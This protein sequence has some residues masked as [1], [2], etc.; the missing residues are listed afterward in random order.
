MSN[1]KH[2]PKK[3]QGRPP[4][5]KRRSGGKPAGGGAKRSSGARRDTAGRDDDKRTTKAKPRRR[6]L[7]GAAAEL[8]NWLID[9]VARTTPK[10]KVADALEAFGEAS[11][12]YTSG[13]YKTALRRAQTAK[14]LAPRSPSV[15]EVLGLAAYR[16]GDYRLALTELR[17]SRRMTGDTTHMPVEMD[18]LRALGRRD[19]VATVYDQLRQ[20][21][22]RP[23]TL[24]EAK[25]VYASHLL[26]EGNPAAAWKLTK[27]GRLG[28]DAY[29]ADHRVWYVAARAAAA[30][31][32]RETAAKIRDAILTADPSFPGI[33][34]LDSEIAKSVTTKE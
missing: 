12:A 14:E 8:P 21:G 27:P 34:E 29:E 28:A 9:E 33:D 19:D 20:L 15:R 25:V 7:R 11:A 24:K 26:D 13:R 1:G 4:P 23:T 18:A 32:D 6:D 10:T 5:A 16:S 17:A 2:K 3:G 22:G 30:L 31:G